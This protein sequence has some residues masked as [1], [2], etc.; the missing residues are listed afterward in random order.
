[1]LNRRT[2]LYLGFSQLIC[3]GISYYLIGGLGDFIVADTHWSRSVVYGGFS[4]ALLMMGVTSP[5]TGRLID[6][7]GGRLVMVI[8]SVLS[9]LGCA[10]LAMSHS[11]FAYY[12][13]WVC[14]GLAMRLTL[15]DA[16]FA[17]LARIAGPNAKRPI[18]QITLLGGLASTVFW[19]IGHFLAGE[20][21]WRGALFVY[22]V[23]ALLTLPLH[24]SLP[25]GRYEAGKTDGRIDSSPMAESPQDRILAGSVFALIVTMINFL[26]AG[27][28][29]HMISILSGLGLGTLISVWIGTLRGIGQSS[30]RLGEI[31]FGRR[32]HPLNLNLMA[33]IVLPFSFAIG[34]LSGRLVMAAVTFAFL[35]G[36]GNG[37]ATI[38]RGTLPLVLFDHR[39]YG[40]FVG[41]LLVPSF[42]LSAAAPIVYAFIIEHIGNSGALYFSDGIAILTFL[43]S[44]VLKM[45][46]NK[47]LRTRQGS[48]ANLM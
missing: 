24:L 39:T 47:N 38:T 12:A 14:L 25:N 15:Y 23:F 8:G 37:I 31:L 21:G 30:A 32:L 22:A 41:K 42:F 10:G 44:L 16:A 46:F 40:A 6:K 34:L 2:V 20:Y 19:P 45:R 17:T 35:Y 27:M 13:S 3:W 36:A 9:A 26:N 43:A 33:T 11:I 5:I 48:L 4:V 18:S 29:A 1:M 28:S 7:Y